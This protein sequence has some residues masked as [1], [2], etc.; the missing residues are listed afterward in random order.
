MNL[1]EKAEKTIRKLLKLTRENQLSWARSKDIWEATRGSDDRVEAF[2][3]A[4]HGE[5]RFRVYEAS[6]QASHDGESLYWTS[7]PRVEIIDFDGAVV[8]R[9]PKSSEMW[10]LLET[11][12]VKAGNVEESLDQFLDGD[13]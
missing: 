13:F 6:Y 11:V 10:D 2:Y 7:E 1:N 8:W 4:K 9:L 3:T 12:K 5:V